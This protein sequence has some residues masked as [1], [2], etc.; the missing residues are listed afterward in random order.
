MNEENNAEEVDI[1]NR[2]SINKKKSKKLLQ[3]S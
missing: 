1:L 2:M 3:K